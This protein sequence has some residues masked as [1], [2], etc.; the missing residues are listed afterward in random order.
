MGQAEGSE[1]ERV[2]ERV[3][4]QGKRGAAPMAGDGNGQGRLGRG[5]R[6]PGTHLRRV[7]GGKHGGGT[8][9]TAQG[10]GRSLWTGER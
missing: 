2:S 10:M 7:A 1:R 6:R 8:P 3:R 9:A 4:K 5:R